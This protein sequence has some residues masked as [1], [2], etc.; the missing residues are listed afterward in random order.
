MIGVTL[1]DPAGVGPEIVARSLPSLRREELVLIGNEANFLR[2]LSGLSLDGT[3]RAV[4]GSW[5]SR[6]RR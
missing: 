1:G 4:T 2:V 6:V 3:D 5:T